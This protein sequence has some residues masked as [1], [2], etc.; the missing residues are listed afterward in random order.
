MKPINSR[1]VFTIIK[2]LKKDF[3]IYVIIHCM[4]SKI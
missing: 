3:S 2:T 4:V 1:D